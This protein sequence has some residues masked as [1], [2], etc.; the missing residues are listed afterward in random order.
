[1]ADR[2][3]G[4]TAVAGRTNSS[5]SCHSREPAGLSPAA[6]THYV[7][8]NAG[9]RLV[10]P[11]IPTPGKVNTMPTYFPTQLTRPADF[12]SPI[13]RNAFVASLVAV[14]A[15]NYAPE[16]GDKAYLSRW[17]TFYQTSGETWLEMNARH[18]A[19]QQAASEQSMLLS[20]AHKEPVHRYRY[21]Q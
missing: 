10:V 12:S 21:P 1:M 5:S 7:R 15:Y 11:M 4:G 2:E 9:L 8:Q 17:I 14:A 3:S 19:K 13:W 20:D 18:T 6:E 16:P